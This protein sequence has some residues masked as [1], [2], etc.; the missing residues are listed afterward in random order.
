MN[1]KR[2]K[3]WVRVIAI[4]LTGALLL[5]AVSALFVFLFWN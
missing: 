4:G 2:Q 3:L 1:E 5:S